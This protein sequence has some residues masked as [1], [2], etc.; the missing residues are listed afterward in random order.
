ME[1]FWLV[2]NILVTYILYQ[3]GGHIE[4]SSCSGFTRG[5]GLPHRFFIVESLN[6]LLINDLYSFCYNSSFLIQGS[7]FQVSAISAKKYVS[8]KK[9]QT[10]TF[11]DSISNCGQSAYECFVTFVQ[12][13]WELRENLTFDTVLCPLDQE[14]L[15]QGVKFHFTP[16][17][18][19]SII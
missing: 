13:N 8:I 6:I 2:A 12:Q 1:I 19:Y 11:I 18:I 14:R 16:E 17:G 5:E 7:N 4:L 3:L 10:N 15:V 9:C